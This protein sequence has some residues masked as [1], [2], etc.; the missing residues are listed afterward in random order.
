M[1]DPQCITSPTSRIRAS[2][3]RWRWQGVQGPFLG[4]DRASLKAHTNDPRDSDSNGQE[5]MS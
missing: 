2:G 1:E 5:C 4:E 3:V